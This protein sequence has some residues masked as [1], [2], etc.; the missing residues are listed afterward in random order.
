MTWKKENRA[1]ARHEHLKNNQ[2]RLWQERQRR[3]RIWRKEISWLVLERKSRPTVEGKLQLDNLKQMLLSIQEETNRW[4]GLLDL[5][6]LWDEANPTA[7]LR[8]GPIINEMGLSGKEENRGLG[9]KLQ[10][11]VLLKAKGKE[12]MEAHQDKNGSPVIT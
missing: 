11:L 6:L 8:Q 1:G 3:G 12:V 2:G 7:S 9:Q 4:L 10:E 5:G